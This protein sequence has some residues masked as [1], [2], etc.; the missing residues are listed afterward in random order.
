MFSKLNG[1]V[2]YMCSFFLFIILN[3]SGITHL[4]TNNPLRVLQ[5]PPPK[6]QNNSTLSGNCNKKSDCYNCSVYYNETSPEP[7]CAWKSGVCIRD[8]SN[9]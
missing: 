4:N 8:N 7:S 1:F 9:T 5:P 2:I 6:N 3:A